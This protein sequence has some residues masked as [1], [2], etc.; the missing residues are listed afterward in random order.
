MGI[1]T[2]LWWRVG[3]WMKTSFPASVMWGKPARGAPTSPLPSTARS[4]GFEPRGSVVI[5]VQSLSCVQLFVTPWTAV[6]QASLSF[7][8]CEFAQTHAT[9]SMMPTNYLILIQGLE[10]VSKMTFFPRREHSFPGARSTIK[11]TQEISLR[12]HFWGGS[13]TSPFKPNLPLELMRCDWEIICTCLQFTRT[14]NKVRQRCLL[15]G[16]CLL[17]SWGYKH[18]SPDGHVG[19]ASLSTPLTALMFFVELPK[20]VAVQL[21]LLAGP[22]SQASVFAYLLAAWPF[23]RLEWHV[24]R[25][26][27]GPFPSLEGGGWGK[28]TQGGR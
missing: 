27:S 14:M 23:P 20:N 25:P 4:L 10:A 24:R 2:G 1:D 19:S 22:V 9:E 8:I 18:P 3:H 6:H 16:S 28:W 5:I 17:A 15:P 11:L 26:G 13:L 21:V 12:Q 7:T